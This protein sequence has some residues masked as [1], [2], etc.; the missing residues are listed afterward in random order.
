MTDIER[1]VVD[2]IN[3]FARIGGL[4]ELLRCLAMITYLSEEKL[5]R[6]LNIYDS[7]ITKRDWS[8]MTG[9]V[10]F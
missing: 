5:V 2:S 1:T 9:T 7:Y 10:F 4:E 6:Y 3:N 8:E